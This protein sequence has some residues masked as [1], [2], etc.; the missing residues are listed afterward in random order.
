MGFAKRRLWV[1][2]KETMNAKGY[3]LQRRI[4][5]QSP[6]VRWSRITIPQRFARLC[7]VLSLVTASSGCSIIGYIISDPLSSTY[8][9]NR[10]GHFY[11]GNR[12]SQELTE[13][14]VFIDREDLYA[15][16]DF[17]QAVWHAVSDPFGVQEFELYASDQPGVTVRFDDASW[18]MMVRVVVVVVTSTGFDDA[19][20]LTLDQLGDNMV[21]SAAG[22]DTWEDFWKTPARDFGC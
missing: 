10:G 13:I 21:D 16:F 18:P 9:V 14:G 20:A 2:A 11:A 3:R 8:M 15:P 6:F 17:E 1:L 22:L 19:I 5:G 7:V 12:C 4:K